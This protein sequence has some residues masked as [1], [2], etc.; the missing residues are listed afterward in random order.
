MGMVSQSLISSIMAVAPF[1]KVL[2]HDPNELLPVNKVLAVDMEN[3]VGQRRY[4]ICP[5]Q[6]TTDKVDHDRFIHNGNSICFLNSI[7]KLENQT[8]SDHPPKGSSIPMTP[9]QLLII[10][11]GLFFFFQFLFDVSYCQSWHQSFQPWPPSEKIAC[12]LRL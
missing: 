12:L 2:L 4:R 3:A 9:R 5:T 1:L 7:I 8:H 10:R 6:R 11:C